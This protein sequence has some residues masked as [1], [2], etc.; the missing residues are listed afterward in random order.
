MSH[1]EDKRV[2]S[3]E[4]EDRKS[5]EQAIADERRTKE[6][7]IEEE[8]RRYLEES[9]TLELFIKQKDL[10]RKKS[11]EVFALEIMREIR[12]S[13]I[14]S[15]PQKISYLDLEIKKL[16]SLKADKCNESEDFIQKI[17]KNQ[18]KYFLE[19]I[20]GKNLPEKEILDLFNKYIVE[21]DVEIK[22]SE[23][24]EIV[25]LANEISRKN[26]ISKEDIISKYESEIKNLNSGKEALLNKRNLFLNKIK[27][28]KFEMLFVALLNNNAN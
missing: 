1:W 28:N 4:V 12:V 22:P 16:E 15:I 14:R 5:N 20:I 13:E 7:L 23:E 27:G 2:R 8:K 17:N 26:L 25:R 24:V 10:S 9:K 11:E 18:C 3:Q 19:N 6:F 21:T